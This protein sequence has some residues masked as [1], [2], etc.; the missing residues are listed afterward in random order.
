MNQPQTQP[1]DGAAGW[2]KPAGGPMTVPEGGRERPRADPARG[3][4]S[5]PP[6]L[7]AL[8]AWILRISGPACRRLQILA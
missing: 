4:S 1:T 5:R 3:W 7:A 6:V 2:G 8:L